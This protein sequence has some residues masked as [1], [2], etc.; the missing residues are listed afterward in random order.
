MNLSD[1]SCEPR[2]TSMPFL[3]GT[4]DTPHRLGMQLYPEGGAWLKKKHPLE[5]VSVLGI[6]RKDHKL[7]AGLVAGRGWKTL[8]TFFGWKAPDVEKGQDC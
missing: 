3:I 7:S 4:H 1:E 5:H 8:K 2:V 6:R